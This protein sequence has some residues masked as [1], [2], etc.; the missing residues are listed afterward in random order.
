MRVVSSVFLDNGHSGLMQKLVFHV[1]CVL[2]SSGLGLA[3]KY[4]A[5]GWTTTNA[6]SL[7]KGV[8]RLCS[9]GEE[10]PAGLPEK[11]QPWPLLP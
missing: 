5:V 4:N 10:G 9:F 3:T 11:P 6:T 1:P 7:K 8:S 2:Q